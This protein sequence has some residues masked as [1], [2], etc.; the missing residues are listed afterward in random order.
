MVSPQRGHWAVLLAAC[1]L[2]SIGS[3]ALANPSPSGIVY[4]HIHAGGGDFCSALP[5]STCQEIVQVTDATGVLNFDMILPCWWLG[6]WLCEGSSIVFTVKWP[7]AW[8]FVDASV[9]G[10]GASVVQVDNGATFSI[11]SMDGAPASGLLVGLGRLVLNVTSE[12]S[13]WFTHISSPDFSC[14]WVGGR[15]SGCG[16]CMRSRCGDWEPMRPVLPAP[17]LELAAGDSGRAVGQFHVDSAG[18][19]D[20]DLEYTFSAS[21]PW[22]TLAPVSVGQSYYPEYDVTVTADA[23]ALA[24]GVHEAWIEVHAPYCYECEW[25]IVTVPETDPPAADEETWGSLKTRFR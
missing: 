10:S 5:V 12:G 25:I 24:P 16:N 4:T 8:Q 7:A 2:A 22:I 3:A 14:D 21:E 15:I 13:T 23:L 9:C 1:A 17:V 11:G 20:G 6:E 19:E 18:F